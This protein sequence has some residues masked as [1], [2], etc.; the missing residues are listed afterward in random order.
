[1]NQMVVKCRSVLQTSPINVNS[2]NLDRRLNPLSA[3]TKY[4]W[5]LDDEALVYPMYEKIV[6]AG[7]TNVCIHKGFGP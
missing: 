7:I 4:P 1:M 2:K 3:A 5:R 6:E